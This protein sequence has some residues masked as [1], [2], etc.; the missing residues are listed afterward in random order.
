MKTNPIIKVATAT[1][2]LHWPLRVTFYCIW[3]AMITA[4]FCE[5]EQAELPRNVALTTKAWEE[6]DRK[7][8]ADAVKAAER[9][10]TAFEASA[11]K[12]QEKLE[13]EKVKTPVGEV[14]PEE[15]TA[16][17][18]NGLLNDVGACYVIKG[19]SL[20]KL[21]KTAEARAAFQAAEKLT[22]ARVWDAKGW[23]WSPAEKAT[24]ELLKLE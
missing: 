5:D 12:V 10:I 15:K 2:Q 19:L 16:I 7:S 18:A 24:E 21:K 23:F 1:F 14:S 13:K 6:Y 17:E 22:H 4:A 3:L 11:N 8:H 20:A 9:C